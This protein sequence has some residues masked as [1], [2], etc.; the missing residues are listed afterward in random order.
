MAFLVANHHI[1]PRVPAIA[2]RQQPG[3]QALKAPQQ[4]DRHGGFPGPARGDVADADDRNRQFAHVRT[5]APAIERAAQ[6]PEQRQAP[7]KRLRRLRAPRARVNRIVERHHGVGGYGRGAPFFPRGG[8]RAFPQR[9]IGG[10]FDNGVA[11]FFSRC[12]AS[13]G[14]TPLEMFGDFPEILKVRSGHDRLSEDGRLENVM[15]AAYR[16]ACLP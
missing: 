8:A 4:F 10:S 11:K 1:M 16:P 6:L 14:L 15:S 13:D 3:F 9:G 12:D 7:Q 2:A 5:F